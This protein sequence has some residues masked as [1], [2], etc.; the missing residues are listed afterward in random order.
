VA[1][2]LALQ[3]F[4][5][6]PN[7]TIR[8]FSLMV[9]AALMALIWWA[10][11]KL[12]WDCTH[13]D[14]DRRSSGQGVLAAAGLDAKSKDEDE[15]E[16]V[17]ESPKFNDPPG[18]AG[19]FERW[20]RHRRKQLEKPHTPGVW[21][22]YFALAALPL[23]GLGQSLIPAED[24]T[25]RRVVFQQM[26]V[27]V[28]SA[29]GLLV[30]TT[31]LGVRKYLRDRGAAMPRAMT[32]GWLLTGAA[33]IVLFVLV[34]AVLPRPHSETPLVRLPKW[35][36]S[37]DREASERAMVKDGSGGEGEGAEGRTE[38]DPDAERGSNSGKGNGPGENRDGEPKAGDG[39]AGQR[40][41]AKSGG[42]KRDTSNKTSDSHEKQTGTKDRPRDGGTYQPS[43]AARTLD[44]ASNVLKWLFWIV[45]ALI[46][47]AAIVYFLLRG[48]A[49][50]TAWAR[51]LLDWFRSLF[52]VKT[53]PSPSRGEVDEPK[54]ERIERPP[55]FE[56]FRNPFDDG[57]HRSQSMEEL[58]EH[59]FAAFDAWAWDRGIGR[60]GKETPQE[61]AARVTAAFPNVDSATGLARLIT[62][63]QFA[64]SPVEKSSQPHLKAVWQQMLSQQD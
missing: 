38:R 59:T 42:E 31:L 32:G 28:A 27:Y 36:S 57:S 19:W 64:E 50:F 17:D 15:V 51:N 56:Q 52:G 33:I 34:G 20:Q 22:L 23:F 41:E 5:D 18:V 55:P 47:L 11:N 14:E 46:A 8:S 26:A 10:A 49:P 58:V 2:L 13:I 60:Q 63:V 54:R 48:L 43:A 45:G 7:L 3:A 30:T 37:R 1:T 62:Q 24:E 40:G 16:V 9:N 25:R 35:A 29:L 44:T 12:T 21:V 6:Y 53:K 39:K 61:F 4:V